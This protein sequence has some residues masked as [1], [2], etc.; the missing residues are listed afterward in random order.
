MT[1]LQCNGQCRSIRVFGFKARVWHNFTATPQS[2]ANF[3]SATG[4]GSADADVNIPAR[5]LTGQASIR[6]TRLG[7]WTEPSS[8]RY[9]LD[10]L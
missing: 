7:N 1:K 9:D 4:P 6:Q 3:Y 2:E 10:W 8:C 5:L